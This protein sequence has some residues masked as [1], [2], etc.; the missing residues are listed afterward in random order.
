MDDKKRK[1][2]YLTDKIARVV[3]VGGRFYRIRNQVK[4]L[5]FTTSINY[6]IIEKCKYQNKNLIRKLSVK[7]DHSQ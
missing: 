3:I 2:N 6:S 5:V 7:R 1:N 4:S